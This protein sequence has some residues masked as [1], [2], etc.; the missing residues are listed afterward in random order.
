MYLAPIST[1]AQIP[2][3]ITLTGKVTDSTGTGI[4]DAVV[5]V[6][7]GNNL[8]AHAR[9][10]TN[11]QGD[12]GQTGSNWRNA[13]IEIANGGQ[14]VLIVRKAGYLPDTTSLTTF[15]GNV[16][17]IS[18]KRDPIEYRIDSVMALMNTAEKIGQMT[19]PER[20]GMSGVSSANNGTSFL[21]GSVLNGGDGYS[22][23]FLTSMVT[24]LSTWPA[25]RARIPTYYGKDAVHGNAGVP[26]Y[27]VFPHNIG[28]G[29]T[30]DSALVRRIG[31]ATAKEMWAARIDLN[32][33][34]AISIAQDQR[35]GRTYESYGETAELSVQMGAAMV[36]GLQGERYNAPWRITATAKHFLADGGTT[37]GRDRGE[38]AATDDVLRAVHLPGYEAVVEQ[39]VLSVMASFNTIRGVH[40]HIDSLRMIEWLKT[41]LGFDGYIISDWQ[42]IANS[43]SPG[44][45]QL[46]DGYGYGACRTEPIPP[47]TTVRPTLTQEAVRKAINAGIDLAME[48]GSHT[49]F[50][51]HLTTLVNNGNIPM[52]RIDD[53][54]RRILRA[55]FRAGRMDN[56]SGPSDYAGVT[57][58]IAH[59]DH[60]TIAREAVA[61]S[62]VLL[63]NENTVLPI[64]KNANI[65]VFGSHHNNIGLQSGGWTITWQGVTSNSGSGSTGGT[66]SF[67]LTT[68]GNSILSGMQQVSGQSAFSTAANADII[69]YV[70]GEE[71]YAE[72]CGDVTS[73]NF[74]AP[75]AD[76]TNLAAYRSQDKKIVTVFV[77][78]RPRIVPA[79][80]DASDAFVAAWLPGTE[81]GG[82][83]DVLFGEKPFT[84]KLPFTWPGSSGTQFAYGF[85]LTDGAVSVLNRDREIP[86][87]TVNPDKDDHSWPLGVTITINEF[88]AGPN[89][90]A[91]SAGTI[92]F[93]WQGKGIENTTLSIYDPYGNR[94][95][96]IKISDKSTGK[97]ERRPIGSWDF[98]NSKGR[99]VSEGNYVVKGNIKT[100]DG[101]KENVSLILGVK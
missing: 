23:T 47:L 72:W 31:E 14:A 74:S 95:N 24:T 89:P 87:P 79:L 52:T 90:V 59:T 39:G 16:E 78:G 11:A 63:K 4:L 17:T 61:K 85:G 81:G 28:L 29:A 49:A 20:G 33:S 71:P 50:N 77:S 2:S 26:G 12:F 9:T 96:K 99:L 25:G 97:S 48:P 91:R 94:I 86:K 18:L 82:V 101:K 73:L 65:H 93:F 19:Q 44:F 7:T 58:N 75:A 6:K 98:T 69:V 56:F 22:S 10:L 67:D 8:L 76:M 13:T 35:W 64:E 15:S 53:A 51:T 54:V 42:G 88:T 3:T 68:Y 70:T 37:N 83:A 84:G 43:N 57:A 38:T 46:T 32:F 36:R 21:Y 27:T 1:T 100:R 34:P 66:P 41:E 92:N 40:Q 45:T 80:I 5:M 62:Q 30:R 55:K 60:R